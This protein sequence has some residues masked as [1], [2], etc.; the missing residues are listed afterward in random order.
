MPLHIC[1]NPQNIKGKLWTLGDYGCVYVGSSAITNVPLWWGMLLVREAHAC[2]WAGGIWKIFVHFTQFHC[3]PKIDLKI[4][5]TKKGSS[6][7]V[8]TT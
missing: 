7:L 2:V 6:L 1:K 8:E 4:K 3:E 5:S